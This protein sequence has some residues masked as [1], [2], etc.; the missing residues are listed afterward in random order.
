MNVSLP[1]YRQFWPWFLMLPPAV[2]MIG[3]FITLWIAMEHA[4][5]V[6]PDRLSRVGVAFQPDYLPGASGATLAFHAETGRIHLR[7]EGEGASTPLTL[8]WLHPTL[9][10]LDRISVLQPMAPGEYEARLPEGLNEARLLRLE[11]QAGWALEGR[12]Q[13]QMQDTPLFPLISRGG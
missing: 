6:L 13:P 9:P 2:A 12:W 7:V 10:E 4:D 3:G 8:R 5:S 11:S 1:W